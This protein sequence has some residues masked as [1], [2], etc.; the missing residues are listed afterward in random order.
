MAIP[1]ST[2]LPITITIT[3]PAF[4]AFPFGTV[5]AALALARPPVGALSLPLSLPLRGRGGG[6]LAEKAEGQDGEEA[7]EEAGRLGRGTASGGLEG[8]RALVALATARLAVPVS[9][10]VF[11]IAVTIAVAAATAAAST[12]TV[13]FVLTVTVA[14]MATA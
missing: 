2:A 3:I 9:G 7:L 8:V 6:L 13:A 4:A 1:V 10:L 5:L 12:G 14:R 11:A